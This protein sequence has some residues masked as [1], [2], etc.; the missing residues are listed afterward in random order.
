LAIPINNP[1]LKKKEIFIENKEKNALTLRSNN[2]AAANQ[3]LLSENQ[4][5]N[6]NQASSFVSNTN[7]GTGSNK[8]IFEPAPL[9]S[10]SNITAN[11]F[12]SNL[13]SANIQTI[14]P[15]SIF[16]NPSSKLTFGSNNKAAAIQPFSFGNQTT[17]SNQAS[18]FVSNT[19]PSTGNNKQILQP[20]TSNNTT[21]GFGSTLNSLNSQSTYPASN[22]TS[23]LTFGSNNKAA[24]I[25]PFSFG[26]QTTNSN[27]ASSFVSNT[28]H[29]TGSNKQIFEPAPL[30]STS[31][32]TANGFGSNLNSANIQTINPVSIFTNP[33]SKLTFGSNNKAAAIQPFS[34]GNQT[35]NSNQASSF[36][37]NTNPSTGNN[38]Q[39]L[40]PATSNNTTNGFGST[41]NSLNSQ[42]TYPASNQTSQ[43]TFG[44]NN[45][46]AAIQPFSF[47][48]QTTNSNQASSFVSNTNHSTGN[49]K[50]I[51]E[52]APLNSTSNITANGFGSNLNSA[53]IQTINPVSIFTNPSSKLTFGSNNKAAAIQPFSF[54]T[55]NQDQQK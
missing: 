11:G 46:A 42:S 7:H 53:N 47:G 26:N 49:N 29:G 25:Q 50:Q 20:A 33:S 54:Q 1:F 19:N 9:N 31:N 18:S 27:Q 44:S 14:N 16:T 22:Q 48:N 6:S 13:N 37:S 8:Q 39:I 5:T 43:L 28:N 2:K 23:Q 3:Q 21:N 45:K 30:N 24:A 36:V 55:Q 34:F 41:L 52:P 10:T 15:V 4:T 17:N 40:Q 35:T 38:K 12:G 51:F 32:I